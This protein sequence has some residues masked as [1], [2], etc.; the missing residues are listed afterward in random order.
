MWI[1]GRGE[2]T[3]LVS[4]IEADSRIKFFGYLDDY[5]LEV[6]AW[7]ADVFV[8]PRPT[9]FGPN[10]LNFPS[11]I[12]FYLSF[13]KPIISTK[14][15]GLSPDYHSVLTIIKDTEL[16][17]T[18]ERFSNYSAMELNQLGEISK[19]FSQKRT[20]DYQVDRLMEWLTKITK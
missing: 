14:S 16:S 2:D 4:A 5:A 19:D 20:W 13:G 9:N 3:E 15:A 7:K 8:N 6:E 12:L 18:L 1:C 11:K 10:L 17:E